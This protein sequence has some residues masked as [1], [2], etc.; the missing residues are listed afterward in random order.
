MRNFF[1][2]IGS[3]EESPAGNRRM[4]LGFLS[5]IG[6]MSNYTNNNDN[7]NNKNN[8]N[9]NSTST[10]ST[11][12]SSSISR[13]NRNIVNNDNN[14]PGMLYYAAHSL[15][16][17]IEEIL[18]DT[19]NLTGSNI[20]G[21]YK[22]LDILNNEDDNIM[23]DYSQLATSNGRGCMIYLMNHLHNPIL[24]DIC[25]KASLPTSLIQGLRLLRMLEIKKTKLSLSSSELVQLST[26]I[27]CKKICKLMIHLCTDSSTIE[28]IRNI[29]I[30]V[31]TF[32]LG[33]IPID[34]LHIQSYS[35][36]IIY[37]IC[38]TGFTLQQV[39]F[40][41]DIQV[42]HQM[43]KTLGE[44]TLTTTT[45]TTA[46]CANTIVSNDTTTNISSNNN[47]SFVN[48]TSSSS[49]ITS[50]KVNNNDNKN[51]DSNDDNRNIV[52]YKED[53][54]SNNNSN[55][56][57]N[58]DD[59]NLDTVDNMD[60]SL[61]NE[62]PTT[63]LSERNQIYD[64]D[65]DNNDDDN[66]NVDHHDDSIGGVNDNHVI[67]MDVGDHNHNDNDDGDRYG[68]G[69]KGGDSMKPSRFSLAFSKE[70]ENSNNYS[71][72]SS[73]NRSINNINGSYSEDMSNDYNNYNYNNDNTQEIRLQ[74][75]C[76]LAEESGMWLIGIKCIVDIIAATSS[77]TPI[78]MSDF[79]ISGGNK[80]FL[81]ILK[82]SSSKRFI[83]VMNI[84][85]QLLFDPLKKSED[86]IISTNAGLIFLDL[87]L[88]ITG[89]N[90]SFLRS[91]NDNNDN[92]HNNNYDIEY[93]IMIS[94]NI[95]NNKWKRLIHYE[96]IIQSMSYSLL[97][98]YS[99]NPFNCSILEEE[100]HFLLI[101][102]LSLPSLLQQDSIIAVLTIF[103]YV[104]ISVDTCS[105]ICCRAICAATH[106]IIQHVLYIINQDDNNN[107]SIDINNNDNVDNDDNSNKNNRT[108]SIDYM[109][110]VIESIFQTIESI[111]KT[112]HEKYALYFIQNGLLRN[113]IFDPF[114][115]LC[116]R[117][118]RGVL[119]NKYSILLH[120]KILDLL[121]IL[122]HKTNQAADDVRDYGLNLLIQSMVVSKII[123]TDFTKTLLKLTI[124]LAIID[125]SHLAESLKTIFTTMIV[126]ENNFTKQ[127]HLTDSL[128]MIILQNDDAA[129]W[130]YTMNGLNHTIGIIIS[131]KDKF[132]ITAAASSE[133]L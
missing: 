60:L 62:P 127:W 32:P 70:C 107:N 24:I 37:S 128:Y 51:D 82:Y 108:K 66:N 17:S 71:N 7:G 99:N 72:F 9:R 12:T 97:T 112:Q 63:F 5:G 124:H 120:S 126:V 61:L 79:D 28:N 74:E 8:K 19:S 40:L 27:P 15:S 73:R 20:Q 58:V 6:N 106:T 50:S 104:C 115:Q 84:I 75:Q 3:N 90:S 109:L 78:L 43:I 113:C 87:L 30:K 91:S 96:Y 34:A 125:K 130:C 117:I 36:D 31:V 57:R 52:Y 39:W 89:L 21:F 29:F 95:M 45:S 33:M 122:I 41:H 132:K 92:N 100:Y 121:I 101:L 44:L 54:I 10:S 102:I 80:L 86:T 118:S 59:Y 131:M 68:Q 77:L 105:I 46:T 18:N 42:I 16:N 85:I 38:K 103:S 11:T 47:S 4:S 98:I 111:I 23:D 35:A 88:D 48:I 116:D 67:H 65:D 119:I 83:L 1:N 93:M 55:S 133:G 123:P 25:I 129:D 56:E 26:I 94:T 14:I 76:Q 22:L 64:D 69:D 2:K 114:V 49:S 110:K 81:H 53:D 13:N